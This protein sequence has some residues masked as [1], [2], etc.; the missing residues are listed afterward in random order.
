MLN[1]NTMPSV[2][3]MAVVATSF[4]GLANAHMYLAEPTPMEGNAIK[5][6]LD[7]SGSNWPCHGAALPTSGGQKLTAGQS[8]PLKLETANGQNTAAHGGGSCQLAILDDVTKAKDPNAWKVIY[9]IEGGCV[10]NAAGNLSPGYKDCTTSGQSE[11]Y[12][13]FP[14][15]PLSKM[16]QFADFSTTVLTLG[17]F[18]FRRE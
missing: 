5:N 1:F 17:T 10:A 14:L 7:A 11:W 3:R 18:L 2:G 4:L 13:K 12:V 9:S 15:P 16:T 6:P 8:F